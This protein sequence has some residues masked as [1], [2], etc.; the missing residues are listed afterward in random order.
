MI[1]RL[2]TLDELAVSSLTPGHGSTIIFLSGN[3][4][5]CNC[6]VKWLRR[7]A[8]KQWS[9]TDGVSRI[10]DAKS[11]QCD[12]PAEL[13]ALPLISVPLKDFACDHDYYYYY[14]DKRSNDHD[15]NGTLN[16][17]NSKTTADY[18]EQAETPINN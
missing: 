15:H 18:S 16:E 6:M 4:W 10:G 7:K 14:D 8:K 12:R 2:I 1:N 3:P 13:E 5:L 9:L 11:L 17:S